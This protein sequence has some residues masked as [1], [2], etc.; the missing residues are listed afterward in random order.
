MT[1]RSLRPSHPLL[2]DQG[3]A[4]SRIGAGVDDDR[5]WTPIL[6]FLR[7]L[8]HIWTLGILEQFTGGKWYTRKGV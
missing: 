4:D 5:V 8:P 7:A 6:K 2:L 3:H 1:P